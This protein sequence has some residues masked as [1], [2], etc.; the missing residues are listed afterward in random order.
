MGDPRHELGIAAEAAV[1]RWLETAGW[2]VLARRQRSASGG[3]VDLIAIDPAEVL[4]AIEVRSRR[5]GRTGTGT[6]AI[7]R[8]RTARI[9]R[10]L[11]AFATGR[12]IAHRGLRVDLVIVTPIPGAVGR[13]RL[14]RVP[15][16]GAW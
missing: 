12:A 10:T 15:E 13:W 4:V 1:A 9:G 5:S 8:R 16:I 14:R 6:E 7:D 2:R 3:E 11:A